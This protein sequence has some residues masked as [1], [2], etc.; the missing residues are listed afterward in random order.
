MCAC[1]CVCV[2]LP[3]VKGEWMAL[4]VLTRCSGGTDKAAESIML[5]KLLSFDYFL[6]FSS[7]DPV[8]KISILQ[9]EFEI[10]SIERL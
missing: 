8:L 7:S 2:C 9:L 5:Q 6:C 4:V 3:S 1:A 10:D